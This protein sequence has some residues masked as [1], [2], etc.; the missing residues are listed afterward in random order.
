MNTTHRTPG[1]GGKGPS[2]GPD[3]VVILQAELRHSEDRLQTALI[4]VTSANAEL[5]TSNEEHQTLNEE[6][7]TANEEL[8]AS[9]DALNS[10]NGALAGQVDA[11][12]LANADMRNVLEGT[13]IAIVF[14]DRALCIRSF[15][16]AI[17]AVLHLRHTDRGRP[18]TD[19]A[20]KVGYDGLGED[21]RHVLRTGEMLGRQ[22][23]HATSGTRYLIRLL[24]YRDAADQVDGVVVTFV[25]ITATHQAQQAL[26]ASEEHFRC[27]ADAVPAILFTAT[28]G[29]AWDYVNAPFYAL[30]GLPEGAALGQGWA[31]TLHPDDREPNRVLWRQAKACGGTM[32]HE[33]RLQ[34]ADGSWCWFLMRA[35]PRQGPDGQ[36]VRWYGSCTDIDER[37]M[38]E[39]RQ[40]ILLAELQHRTKNI[41]AVVR[42]LLTRTLVSSSDLSHFAD[43]LAGRIGAL[44]RTQAVA[45]RTAEGA[46]M[47]EDL[48]YE[49]LASNGGHDE[50]QVEVAG[51]PV[52][53]PAKTA[54]TLSLAIHELATNAVKYGALAAPSGRIAVRWQIGADP[55]APDRRR[56]ALSWVESGVPLT[57]LSPSYRGFGRDLIDQVLPYELGAKTNLTFG[58]GGVRCSIALSLPAD[59]RGRRHWPTSEAVVPSYGTSKGVGP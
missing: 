2:A 22:A 10:A 26:R 41:L 38:A 56:L 31:A 45:A 7:R 17:E 37:R 16:P 32:E 57:D 6:L 21:A 8:E 40:G 4:E 53:L 52:A 12:A 36:V 23:S 1:R 48:I 35:V 43:H 9:E 15:T 49:E 5:R 55:D 27:M 29:L 46:V 14:L 33:A 18:V 47:L 20:L 39:T 11:L 3:D 58:P 34:R 59:L 24:P 44:A 13:Q 51:P 28:A 19:L 30:S 50:R 54:D 42:S 25:D